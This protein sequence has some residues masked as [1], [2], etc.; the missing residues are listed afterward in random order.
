MSKITGVF[1]SSLGGFMFRKTLSVFLL[2]LSLAFIS[3]SEDDDSNP[4]GTGNSGEVA[5]GSRTIS[6]K[7]KQRKYDALNNTYSLID[8]SYGTGKIKM[9]LSVTD[10]IAEGTISADGSFSIKLPEKVKAGLFA[11]TATFLG[12]STNPNDVEQTMA[13]YIEAEYTDK[14]TSKNVK[15]IFNDF[16]DNT[17][18]SYKTFY[19]INAFTKSGTAK[20]KNSFSEDTYD[21]DFNK[22]WNILS[23]EANQNN[24]YTYV[25]KKN[26]DFINLHF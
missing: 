14:G 20:G 13:L 15:L 5:I 6:G 21:L 2:I 10:L 12:V 3:C 19:S 22:G 11:S 9:S 26:D 8:W 7:I 24:K 18:K 1:S 4:A 17:Y 16:T 25:I 23:W